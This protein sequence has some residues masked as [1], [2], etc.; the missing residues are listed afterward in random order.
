MSRS[1]LIALAAA[2]IVTAAMW[3]AAVREVFRPTY[4]PLLPKIEAR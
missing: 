2:G 4:P 3:L 1:V